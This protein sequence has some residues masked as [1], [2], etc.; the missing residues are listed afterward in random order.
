MYTVRLKE[1]YFRRAGATAMNIEGENP[2]RG[3]CPEK[4]GREIFKKISMA[5][6]IRPG[7]FVNWFE[8]KEK[9]TK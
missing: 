9:K 4:R 5:G 6:R 1:K 3:R 7:P 2:G 8:R